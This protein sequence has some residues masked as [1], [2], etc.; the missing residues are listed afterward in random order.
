MTGQ[1]VET[2]VRRFRRRV[3][4]AVG[5]TAIAL[6]FGLGALIMLRGGGLPMPIDEEWAEEVLTIRGPVG[7]VLAGFMN[8]L[9]GGIVGVIL[10]PAGGAILLVVLG[11]P[12]AALY[13]VVASAVSAAIVQLLKELFGRDRPEDMLVTSD[14]GSFPSGHVANAATIAVVVGVIAPRARVWAAGVAYTALMAVSRTYL[15]VHWVTDT[16][17]G[18][19]VGAGAALLVWAVLAGPLERERLAWIERMSRRNAERAQAHV[20][21]PAGSARS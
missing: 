9:G 20:T 8:W 4:I 12:W 19:L 17:G 2:R 21:P 18:A 5:L 3:P 11:R 13:F 6:A 16:I 1:T 7:D 10:I 14:F 15:G